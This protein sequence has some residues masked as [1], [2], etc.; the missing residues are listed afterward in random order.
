MSYI[1]LT[2]TSNHTKSFPKR[3][4]LHAIDGFELRVKM[5]RYC[6]A[7]AAVARKLGVTRQAVNDTLLGRYTSL[8][9][10]IERVV[11]KIIGIQ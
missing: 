7:G 10:E 1:A 3:Q 8:L 6:I 4:T 9:P 11:N 2:M 5:M